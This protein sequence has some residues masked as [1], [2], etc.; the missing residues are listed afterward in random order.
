MQFNPKTLQPFS[1]AQALK[2]Y[3]PEDW[4]ESMLIKQVSIVQAQV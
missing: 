3:K 1:N 4:L 2:T